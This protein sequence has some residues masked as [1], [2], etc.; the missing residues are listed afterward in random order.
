MK[1]TFDP[2]RR[3]AISKMGGALSAAAGLAVT[4]GVG[5]LA[6]QSAGKDIPP[7]GA[8]LAL[9][10]RELGLPYDERMIPESKREDKHHDL[11]DLSDADELTHWFRRVAKSLTESG[12]YSDEQLVQIKLAMLEAES[13]AK[14][15]RLSSVRGRS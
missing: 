10:R 13:S 14:G 8:V 11:V 7:S 12:R 9:A 6:A 2:K 5:T 4:G 3:N 1:N 15:G